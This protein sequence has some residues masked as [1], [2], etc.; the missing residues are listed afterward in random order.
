MTICK[1]QTK[2]GVITFSLIHA[3][4]AMLYN[5]FC[6]FAIF[7]T[8]LEFTLKYYCTAVQQ[9]NGCLHLHNIKP[10]T[11]VSPLCLLFLRPQAL[12]YQDPERWG[13]TLQTYIQ[14]TMLDGHLSSGVSR[15]QLL[16]CTQSHCRL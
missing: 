7:T 9:Q 11:N 15:H 13:I 14:L 2:P 12:M 5:V 3:F 6:F 8:T 4:S 10:C 1:N 16:S